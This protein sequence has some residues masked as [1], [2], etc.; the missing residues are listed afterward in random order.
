MLIKNR[1]KKIIP[2]ARKV[3]SKKIP[4]KTPMLK[5]SKLQPLPK[6]LSKN[7]YHHDSLFILSDKFV[8]SCYSNK[9]YSKSFMKE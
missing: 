1:I 3:M 2:M 7:D 6:I 4:L 9:I 5:K 8:Q